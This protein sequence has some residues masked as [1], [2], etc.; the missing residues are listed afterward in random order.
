[1]VVFDGDG[2]S[3]LLDFFDEGRPDFFQKGYFSVNGVLCGKLSDAGD[4]LE[5]VRLRGVEVEVVRIYV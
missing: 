5:E 4:C 3:A 2:L 1:V